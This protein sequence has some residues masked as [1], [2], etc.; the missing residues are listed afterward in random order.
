MV[1]VAAKTTVDDESA[2]CYHDFEPQVR[3]ILRQYRKKRQLSALAA[4]VG[5]NQ[6]RLAEMINKN[7]KGHY[8]RRITPYYLSKFLDKGIMTVE[9]LLEGRSIEE[10][11][12][13]VGIFFERHILSRKTIRLVIEAQKRG[14]DVDS[15]LQ[16]A[17]FPDGEDP[18]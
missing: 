6:T 12:D 2:K 10:F 15:M 16:I 18:K 8:K 11:P 1:S 4:T 17:L 7:S 14:I 9:E 5:I 3:K 13:R